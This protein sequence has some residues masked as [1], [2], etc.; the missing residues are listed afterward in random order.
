ME[1]SYWFF[2]FWQKLECAWTEKSQICTSRKP[3]ST[4]PYDK[5]R[6]LRLSSCPHPSERLKYALWSPCDFFLYTTCWYPVDDMMLELPWWSILIL[7]RTLWMPAVFYSPRVSCFLSFVFLN[8]RV[9]VVMT[10]RVAIPFSVSVPVVGVSSPLKGVLGHFAWQ[11]ILLT[12]SFS[13]CWWNLLPSKGKC[14]MIPELID[15][16]M[17]CDE[18]W[19]S[20]PSQPW[21]GPCLT[22][23]CI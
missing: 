14:F 21:G 20:R 11:K 7:T 6:A 8:V 5:W 1:F 23:V 22:P 4:G 12:L 13:S 17:P 15:A 16:R 10:G 3:Y 19:G 2:Y 9:P 18:P